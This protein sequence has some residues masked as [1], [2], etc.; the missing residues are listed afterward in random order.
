MLN[1]Y[2]DSRSILLKKLKQ[3]RNVTQRACYNHIHFCISK[4]TPEQW[5]DL[6]KVNVNLTNVYSKCEGVQSLKTFLSCNKMGQ[7]IIEELIKELK[8]C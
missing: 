2:I 8:T 1:Q 4:M 6:L 7:K 5:H 3:S